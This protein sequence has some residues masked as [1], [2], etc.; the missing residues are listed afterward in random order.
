MKLVAHFQVHSSRHPMLVAAQIMLLLVLAPVGAEAAAALAACQRLAKQDPVGVDRCLTHVKTFET[1]GD[2]VEACANFGDSFDLRFR[3]LK[4]GADQEV[5]R[6]CSATDWRP[7]TKLSCLRAN[8]RRES[9]QYCRRRG[10][11]EEAQLE[12]VRNGVDR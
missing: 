6:L 4:S 2:I 9:M 12:C 3:C 7:D 1:P 5:F 10:G 11:P 8:P